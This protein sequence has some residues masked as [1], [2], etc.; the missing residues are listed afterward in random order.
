MLR[1]IDARAVGG[2][3]HISHE[4]DVGRETARNHLRSAKTNFFLHRRHRDHAHLEFVFAR[5]N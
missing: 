5:G 4:C 2:V 3:S 1:V